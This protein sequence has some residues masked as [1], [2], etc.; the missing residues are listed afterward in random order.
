[1]AWSPT[2]KR[3]YQFL[4]QKVICF[5]FKFGIHTHTHTHTYVYKKHGDLVRQLFAPLGMKVD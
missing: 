5:K 3:S 4:R 1:M 2:E